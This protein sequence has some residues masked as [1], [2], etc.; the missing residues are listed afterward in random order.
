MI[1]TSKLQMPG[2]EPISVYRCMTCG[3]LSTDS[4]AS[5]SLH[6]G[7]K[8]KQ[9]CDVSFFEYVGLLFGLIK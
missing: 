8:M 3:R 6:G 2:R 5:L 4:S 7:H 1:V 9:P